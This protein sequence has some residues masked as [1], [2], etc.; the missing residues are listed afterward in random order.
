MV[1]NMSYLSL[2]IW[3]YSLCTSSLIKYRQI[4]PEI[5]LIIENSLSCKRKLYMFLILQFNAKLTKLNSVQI[6]ILSS[7]ELRY[8]SENFYRGILGKRYRNRLG[9]KYIVKSRMIPNQ[10]CLSCLVSRSIIHLWLIFRIQK[11]K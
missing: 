1:K 3:K 9:L 10:M 7:K 8:S 11:Y 4:T 2:L 6:Y 5:L